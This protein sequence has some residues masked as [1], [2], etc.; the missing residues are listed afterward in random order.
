[1]THL[2]SIVLSG[3]DHA[4]NK[5]RRTPKGA[6]PSHVSLPD[7]PVCLHWLI[8]S[9]LCLREFAQC[10]SGSFARDLSSS[11]A[12]LGRGKRSMR[13]SSREVRQPHCQQFIFLS[14]EYHFTPRVHWTAEISGVADFEPQPVD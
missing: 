14:A 1:M 6:C 13:A 7:L 5:I 12:P 10:G 11:Q 8:V 4:Q 9:P 3:V 2:M